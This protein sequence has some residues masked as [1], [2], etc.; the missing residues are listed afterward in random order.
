MRVTGTPFIVCLPNE[1]RFHVVAPGSKRRFLC[2]KTFDPDIP[3]L[4]RAHVMTDVVA[5][6]C[7]KTCIERMCM[8][9]DG[10][11]LKKI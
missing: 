1:E 5:K 10:Y 3:P 7:C 4:A 9:F 6:V 2:G 11:T 8:I